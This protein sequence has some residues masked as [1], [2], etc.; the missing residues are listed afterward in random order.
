MAGVATTSAPLRKEFTP[1]MTATQVMTMTVRVFAALE[2]AGVE[3]VGVVVV[4]VG[5]WGGRMS[6]LWWI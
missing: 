2:A 5:E 1:V 6:S 3:T 4:V